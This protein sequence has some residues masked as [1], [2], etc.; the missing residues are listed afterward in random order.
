MRETDFSSLFSLV[1]YNCPPHNR[2]FLT[3]ASRLYKASSWTEITVGC[4]TN[5][6]ALTLMQAH[7]ASSAPAAAWVG[8]WRRLRVE[9]A[10]LSL[11]GHGAAR[12]R[13]PGDHT[14]ARTRTHTVAACNA[15]CAPGNDFAPPISPAHRGDRRCIEKK[16]GCDARCCTCLRFRPAVPL[17]RCDHH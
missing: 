14:W 8:R 13:S 4:C 10:P 9:V 12:A 6:H 11:S 15:R 7:R 5:S 2:R 17:T 16:N 3:P 1:F